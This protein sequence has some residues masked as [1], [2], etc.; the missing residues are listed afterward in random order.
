MKAQ[1]VELGAT[2]LTGSPAEF[3][4][5]IAAEAGKWRKVIEFA[6]IKPE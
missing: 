2:V 5:F 6:D 1:L 4:T 3:G